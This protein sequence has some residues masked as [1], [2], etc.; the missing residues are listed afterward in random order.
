MSLGSNQ[1]VSNVAFHSG[2]FGGEDPFACLSQLLEAACIAW[3]RAASTSFKASRVV[4]S[5]L[6]DTDPLPV[7][8][9]L[10]F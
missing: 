8:S 5:D 2:G 1:G 4:S 3:L 10:L 9:H 7:L 6:C